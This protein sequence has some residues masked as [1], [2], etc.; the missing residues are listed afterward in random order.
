[1]CFLMI[2]V[3]VG[4]VSGCS[5]LQDRGDYWV[6]DSHAALGNEPRV[7][8]LIFHYTAENEVNSLAVLT[9]ENVSVHYLINP[10]PDEVSG[11]PVVLQLVPENRRAWHAGASFWRGRMNLN[12]TSV[13]IELVNPGYH[14]VG[15]ERRWEPYSDAQIA[16]LIA[17]SNDIIKR[18]QIKPENVL[19]HSDVSPQRKVDPGPLF[20]WQKLAQA[21]IGAWPDAGRVSHYLAIRQMEKTPD[22]AALQNNLN[23]YGYQVPLTGVLDD[24]TRRVVKAF[25]MHFR[26]ANYSGIPDAETLAIL[27]ALL[28]KYRVG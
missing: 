8:F 15:I 10:L 12:D 14:K 20:P 19:G 1:M 22:I 9:G 13:G 3:I 27:D 11:K 23:R 26:Q 28:E 21:G 4:L 25:Q 5:S 24:E 7:S 18:N 17:L 6:D 16:S 2:S